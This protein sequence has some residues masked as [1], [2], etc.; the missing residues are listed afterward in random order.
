MTVHLI[1]RIDPTQIPQS[2]QHIIVCTSWQLLLSSARRSK[3]RDEKSISDFKIRI[4]PEQRWIGSI[5][6]MSLQVK[7]HG[8]VWRHSCENREN[9]IRK[10]VIEK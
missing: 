1:L 3:T 6:N 8:R 9:G 4:T 2:T 5:N 7:T 10:G